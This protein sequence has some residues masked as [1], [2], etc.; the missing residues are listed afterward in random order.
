[1]TILTGSKNDQNLSI[2][3]PKIPASRMDRDKEYGVRIWP[4]SCIMVILILRMERKHSNGV[5]KRNIMVL[6][7][8]DTANSKQG[9][10]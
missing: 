3:H 5:I 4:D 10:E 8:N 2:R 7:N 9:P 6:K 1:M